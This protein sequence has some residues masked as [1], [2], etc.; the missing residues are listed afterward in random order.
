MGYVTMSNSYTTI[1]RHHSGLPRQR[2]GGGD[3][4]DAVEKTR[5]PVHGAVAGGWVGF[6]ALGRDLRDRRLK[7]IAG[8]KQQIRP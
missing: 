1:H 6:D 2:G 7:L 3:A 8:L 4:G 5:P